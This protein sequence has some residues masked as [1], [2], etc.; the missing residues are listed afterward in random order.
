MQIG[1]VINTI[2]NVSSYLTSS[3]S[4]AC[5]KTSLTKS[6]FEDCNNAQRVFSSARKNARSKG[7]S[8]VK[9]LTKGVSAFAKEVGPVPFTTAVA[10]FC[11]LPIGGTSIGLISGLIA[12]KGL[13]YLIN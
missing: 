2:E 13:K 1:K 5:N 8:H 10:G 11:F 12:K 9:S 3:I 6:V 4:K 7:N